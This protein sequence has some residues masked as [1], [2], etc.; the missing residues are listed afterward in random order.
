MYCDKQ[1]S[2]LRHSVFNPMREFS[3]EILLSLIHIYIE[4]LC[5]SHGYYLPPICQADRFRP[6]LQIYI[7]FLPGHPFDMTE[8]RFGCFDAVVLITRSIT[9]DK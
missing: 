6:E 4:H 9:V 2:L 3:I 5:T 8:R 1:V 7:T